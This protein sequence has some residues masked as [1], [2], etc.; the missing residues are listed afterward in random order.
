MKV[1]QSL[2]LK[3]EIMIRNLNMSKF[4]QID[5]INIALDFIAFD[6]GGCFFFQ[7]GCN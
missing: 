3:T 6:C 5:W 4:K 1:T 2:I 7:P